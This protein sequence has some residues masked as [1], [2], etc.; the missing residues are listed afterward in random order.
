MRIAVLDK[1]SMG[2][3]LDF[4]VLSAFGEY[5]TYSSTDPDQLVSHASDCDVLILNKVKIGGEQMDMLPR[6]RQICVF[7]TGFDNIDVSAASTRGIAVCNVPAYSTD[8][9]ALITMATVLSLCTGLAARDRYV[10]SGKYRESGRANS[11]E[12]T[13]RELR[14]KVWGIVGYGNIGVAVAEVAKAFGCRIV[15]CKRTPIQG[16]ELVDIDTL[17]R[18]SDII[19]LH[20]PLNGQTRG[21]ISRERIAA[22]KQGVVL[23]NEARGAVVDEAAVA[24]A[25]LS[26]HIGAFGCD[27]YSEEPFNEKHPYAAIMGCENVCLTPHCAWGAVEARERCLRII[28]ENIAAF[29]KGEIKNRVDIL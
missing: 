25:V 2:N 22:M 24:D 21:I 1:A 18:I 16:V 13:F 5:R 8:S 12:P 4:D 10:K 3:D 23:V 27:V 19:T 15:A 17:C 9:V 11:L 14:G 28:C 20:C 29:E 26:G 6:L 7:A